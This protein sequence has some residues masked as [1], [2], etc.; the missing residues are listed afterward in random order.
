MSGLCDSYESFKPLWCSSYQVFEAIG[1]WD[2]KL[3]GDIR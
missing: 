1:S 2:V 3:Y